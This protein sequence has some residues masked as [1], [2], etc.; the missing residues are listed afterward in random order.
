M[1]VNP[2]VNYLYTD[3]QDCLII[4]QVFFFRLVNFKIC[5][6]IFLYLKKNSYTT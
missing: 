4:F 5:C 6:L 2:Y 1:G 3:L